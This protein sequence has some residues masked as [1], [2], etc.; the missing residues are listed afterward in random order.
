LLKTMTAKSVLVIADDG[1]LPLS[2]SGCR[3]SRLAGA[4]DVGVA[5]VEEGAGW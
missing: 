4:T 1:S 3:P 5:T 2:W